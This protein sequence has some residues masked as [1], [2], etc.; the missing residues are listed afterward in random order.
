MSSAQHS[1]GLRAAQETPCPSD[2]LPENLTLYFPKT[3]ASNIPNSCNPLL[4]EPPKR[5]LLIFFGKP[6]HIT[7]ATTLQGQIQ[8]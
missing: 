5:V 1:P 2:G 8:A 3:E 6:P 7:S 4:C